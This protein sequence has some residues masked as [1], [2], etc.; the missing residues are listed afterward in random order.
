[1]NKADLIDAALKESGYRLSK[2]ECEELV[3]ARLNKIMT[4]I[5][6]KEIV[7]IQNVGTFKVV[8]GKPRVGRVVKTG[9][10]VAIPAKPR[11]KF[12]PSAY[13][14]RRLFKVEV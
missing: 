13:I 2:I 6:N 4:S 3:T 10:T 1:M 11:V 5:L 7:T 8:M 9:K 12:K 14:K